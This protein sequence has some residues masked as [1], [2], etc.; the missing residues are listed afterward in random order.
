[1]NAARSPGAP[2]AGTPAAGT[3][4][5][6]LLARDNDLARTLAALD[7]DVPV[8][9]LGEAGVGKTS[10][11]RAAI[12][13]SGRRRFEGGGFASLSWAP[14]L[15]LERAVGRSF[16]GADAAYVARETARTVGSGV[17]FLDDLQWADS[18][19]RA[20]AQ[21][22]A[23]RLGLVIGVRTG[24]PASA[25]TLETLGQLQPAAI[26]VDLHPLDDDVAVELARRVRPG[27]GAGAARRIA[28]RA[29]GNPLLVTE[30][31]QGSEDTV[32]LGGVVRL[33][34]AAL[35]PDASD[36][37]AMLAV[38][39]HPLRIAALGPG[40]GPLASA[41]LAITE[42]GGRLRVRHE[43]IAAA[44]AEALDP[45][46]RRAIHARLAGLTEDRGEAAR[47][48]YAAGEAA[49][50]HAAATDAAASASTPGEQA[51]HLELAALTAHPEEAAE[52]RVAAALAL[53][54]AEESERA[55]RLLAE[56]EDTGRPRVALAR[57]WA[58]RIEYD[59]VQAR[60]DL[61]RARE[62]SD[63]ADE[64]LAVELQ[65][66]AARLEAAEMGDRHHILAVA[67][68]ADAAARRHGVATTQA[69]ALLGEAR[70]LAGDLAGIDDLAAAQAAADAEGDQASAIAIGD[71]LLF[72]LLKSGRQSEGLALAERLAARA[73]ELG[74]A[75]WSEAM[76]LASAGF[77]WHGGDAAGVV[78]LLERL[79]DEQ[80]IR[81]E[82][83][84]YEL[85]ALA[86]LGRLDEARVRM[87]R[88]LARAVP[89]EHSLGVALWGCADIALLG[90]RWA[91]TVEYADRHAREVPGA[92]HRMFI[93]VA[94]AWA[95]VELGRPATWPALQNGMPV[96]EGGS[97]ELEALRAMAGGDLD[98][99]V[100]GF[101]AAAEAWA[102]RHAR[103]ER[104][105]R[106]AAAES[107]RRLGQTAEARERLLGLE[108]ELEAAEEVPI[109][110]RT[111]RSLRLL[112]EHRA[113]PSVRPPGELLTER[114]REILGLSGRGVR[115]AEIA[116]RLGI[117]RWAVVRSAES[118]AGKLGAASRAEAVA[119]LSRA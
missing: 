18:D 51:A 39:G 19:T 27:L 79:R 64:K 98:A 9:V 35:D 57:A 20:V 21:Q 37:M 95:T 16:A 100:A 65:V 26:I 112:G 114:E 103:G 5:L 34:L 11:A 99:A 31:A 82:T 69:R 29:G 73:D 54:P 107:L 84:W 23:G 113:A 52:L 78:R 66:E 7:A 13:A 92:H 101:D 67:I 46:A 85:Q 28:Q 75:G 91:D 36:A 68:E 76:R 62:V 32:T 77:A 90:G 43:L 119:A 25:D 30:L 33:R 50:A 93:E 17:L 80:A 88:F 40:A 49:L 71:E 96:D 2:P 94:R 110:A 1:M 118:A 97:I 87:D 63:P 116:A 105:S 106:W 48:L 38:A 61:E 89:G 102:G 115:D 22:L 86:D 58:H 108:A 59:L 83:T 12:Q 8:V 60:K 72:A 4:A 24:D 15:A 104:R 3:S 56:V 6:D 55:L 45:A 109:R 81:A 74:L 47:H 70:I 10:L 14:F 41:G 53:L 42:A 117:S 111:Q 44:A